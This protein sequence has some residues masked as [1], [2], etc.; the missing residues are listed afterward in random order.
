M[1]KC[2]IDNVSPNIE[3]FKCFYT[4]CFRYQQSGREFVKECLQSIL[5]YCQTIKLKLFFKKTWQEQRIIIHWDETLAI[6]RKRLINVSIIVKNKAKRVATAKN[7][8]H[9]DKWWQIL[10]WIQL[11]KND[12]LL[13]F[14]FLSCTECAVGLDSDHR[15]IEHP[16]RFFTLSQHTRTKF[17]E[18]TFSIRSQARFLIQSWFNTDCNTH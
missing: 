6:W 7:R 15:N 1:R 14:V 12:V 3:Q 2:L 5:A 13:L 10:I 18:I 17:H 8:C 16:S 9:P 4:T 11:W